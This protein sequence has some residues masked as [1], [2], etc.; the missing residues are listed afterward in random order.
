MKNVVAQRWNEVEFLFD[1]EVKRTLKIRLRGEVVSTLKSMLTFS[2]IEIRRCFNACWILT[3][4]IIFKFLYCKYE[5]IFLYQFDRLFCILFSAYIVYARNNSYLT[6]LD[7][8]DN[9][10]P[11][12]KLNSM[13]KFSSNKNCSFEINSND[14]PPLT[15]PGHFKGIINAKSSLILESVKSSIHV[16]EQRAI[17]SAIQKIYHIKFD[18][19]FTIAS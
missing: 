4:F 15:H 7:I 6:Q 17:G 8:Y 19:P 3:L 11:Y 5:Y 1:L 10:T 9:M 18:R 12:Q 16:G 2:N 13:Y 14:T